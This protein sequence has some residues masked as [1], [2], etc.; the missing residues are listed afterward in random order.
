MFLG[1]SGLS[2]N[3]TSLEVASNNVGNLNTVGYKST[4]ANFADVLGRTIL[5][6]SQSVGGGVGL[7]S[8]E[9]QFSQGAFVSTGQVLDLAISGDGFFPV[10]GHHNGKEGE[11]YSRSGQFHLDSSG[12][13]VNAQNLK[14]QGF[15]P[16]NSGEISGQTGSLRVESQQLPP[17]PT[18]DIQL[19]MLFNS[20]EELLGDESFNPDIESTYQFNTTTAV[21]DS[22]GNSHNLEIFFVKSDNQWTWHAMTDKSE[23]EPPGQPGEFFELG[24][25]VLQFDDNGNQ[26]AGFTGNLSVEWQ[27]TGTQEM[28]LSFGNQEGSNN[29]SV[30]FA[31]DIG[32][33]I[34]RQSQ[35][36]YGSATMQ[37]VSFDANGVM[38]GNYSNGE[39]LVL[40]QVALATVP[41]EVGLK[42]TDSNLF[43]ATGAT[44]DPVLGHPGS[45]GRGSLLSGA[46]EQSNVDLAEQFV[47]IIA[48]QRGFQAS[49]KTISTASQMYEDAVNLKKG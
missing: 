1:Y 43:E 27:G 10:K 6:K 20:A 32:T 19:E 35:D 42:A 38:Y 24:T 44:G 30:Q 13:V 45:M 41:S 37:R 28:T 15:M 4:R 49:S 34:I 18:Q 39:R 23:I 8:I 47:N 2:A 11:F 22:L 12:Y 7:D 21:Y 16:G 5:G 14:L 31:S 26:T 25:G 17:N 36:G 46:L 29:T 40:G 9:R 33:Q 3:D 48:A